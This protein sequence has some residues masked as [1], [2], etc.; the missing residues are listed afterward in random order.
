METKIKGIICTLKNPVAVRLV[1]KFLN[2]IAKNYPK[3][4]QKIRSK[5][6]HIV[7]VPKK[8]MKDGTSGQVVRND[9]VREW[10]EFA[11]VSVRIDESIKDKE[12]LLVVV[13][14]EFGHVCTTEFDMLRRCAPVEEYAGEAAAD[15]YAYKWGYGKI[16]RKINVKYPRVL[17]HHG[18]MPGETCEEN[19]IEYRLTRNF[20]YRR[21]VDNKIDTQ[22]A[23]EK[24]LKYLAANK[25]DLT[26]FGKLW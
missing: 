24:T 9:G 11:K 19:S 14:H 13:A 10:A 15:W 8:D 12:H 22:I 26:S 4:F 18:C 5:T 20:V 2:E 6:T 23:K 7:R 16:S 17:L 25:L 1:E 21:T 3:D